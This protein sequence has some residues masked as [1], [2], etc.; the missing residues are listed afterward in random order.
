M[1]G[2]N[3]HVTLAEGEKIGRARGFL[4]HRAAADRQ[5]TSPATGLPMSGMIFA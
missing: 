2:D 5:L 3:R 4:E 1:T